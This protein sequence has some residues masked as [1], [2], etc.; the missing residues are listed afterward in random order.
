MAEPAALRAQTS[1]R[2]LEPPSEGAVDVGEEPGCTR[3]GN[4]AVEHR[5]WWLAYCII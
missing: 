3:K 4:I 5:L 2:A 1:T